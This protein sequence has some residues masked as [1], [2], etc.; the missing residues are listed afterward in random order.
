MRPRHAPFALLGGRPAARGFTFIELMMAVAIT[1]SLI[2]VTFTFYWFAYKATFRGSDELNLHKAIRMKLEILERDL[3]N[4][5]EI[6]EIGPSRLSLKVFRDPSWETSHINLSGDDRSMRVVYELKKG[7]A[8]GRD[9]ILRTVDRAESRF[10]LHD[11]IDPA[12][13]TAR[14]FDLAGRFVVFDPVVNDSY[15][16]ERISLVRIRLKLRDRG[17]TL[18]LSGEVCPR[19]L[20]GKK[21]DPDWNFNSNA[22]R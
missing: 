21:T 8:G 18:E 10:A 4:A 15:Q 19:F 3:R 1:A 22:L 6:E 12:I 16:R 5:M 13:F 11:E 14:T 17:T 9:V 2:G 20:H 7:G